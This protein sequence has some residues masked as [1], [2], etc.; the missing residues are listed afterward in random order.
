MTNAIFA[1]LGV[2]AKTAWRKAIPA[3]LVRIVAIPDPS[4]AIAA[5]QAHVARIALA[6]PLCLAGP[7]ADVDR[8]ASMLSGPLFTSA[9]YPWPC[10]GSRWLEPVV[11]IDLAWLGAVGGLVLEAGLVQVWTHDRAAQVRIIPGAAVHPDALVPVP[12]PDPSA[13]HR[14]TRAVGEDP[15]SWLAD[16]RAIIGADA[17]FLDCDPDGLDYLL[18]EALADDPA[19]P[20]RALLDHA[21]AWAALQVPRFV[22]RAFGMASGAVDTTALPPVLLT[23]EEDSRISWGDGGSGHLCCDEEGQIRFHS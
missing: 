14:R 17:P 1:L 4:P 7:D 20:L 16:G 21:R 23:I 15:R 8:C 19:A 18:G 5:V 10:A 2:E 13:W 12:P 11:Q 6:F 9:D 22:H 3:P